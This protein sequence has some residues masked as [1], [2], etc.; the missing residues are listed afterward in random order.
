MWV[1]ANGAFEPIIDHLLFDA[2]QTIIRARSH[3]VS[4]EDMLTGLSRLF[5]EHGY[6]SGLIIDETGVL[7]SSSCYRTRFGS[8]LRAYQLVGFTPDRDYCYVEINRS[9]RAMHPGVVADTIAGIEAAGGRIAQDPMTELLTVNEEF[10]VS[11]VIVRCRETPTG[12]LRWH[13]RLDTGLRP[14]ITVAVRMGQWNRDPF[15]YYLL[16]WLDMHTS[17]LRMAEANGLALDA[18]RFDSLEALFDLAARIK[19]QDVA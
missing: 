10:T 17:R 12:A 18:Y 11:I 5:E 1:R 9:L 7:P 19:L 2:A 3:R 8:L 14:D 4:D 13:I 15:D 6:L 16:P